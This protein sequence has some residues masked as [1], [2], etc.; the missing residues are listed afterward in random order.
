MPGKYVRFIGSLNL[1]KKDQYF[2]QVTVGGTVGP[3]WAKR[4][5]NKFTCRP[6][7]I[8]DI[9]RVSWLQNLTIPQHEIVEKW[10]AEAILPCFGND[11]Q[12]LMTLLYFQAFSF[13]LKQT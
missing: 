5:I 1:L 6:Y 4:F 2:T 3:R 12:A 10:N 11:M 13:Q 8:S 7:R 9:S